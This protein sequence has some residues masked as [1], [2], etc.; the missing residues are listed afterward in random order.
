MSS[1]LDGAVDRVA[2]LA[3]VDREIVERELVDGLEQMA[4]EVA[5]SAI[6]AG[7]RAALEAVDTP[8][9]D[10]ATTALQPWLR[11]KLA[12]QQ[13][14]ATA[15]PLTEAARRLGVSDSAVRHVVGTHPGDGALLG[16]RDARKRWRIFTYQLPGA[17]GCGGEPG[18]A[19]GRRVQQALPPRMH[20][21]AVAAWWD[22]PHPGLLTGGRELTPR[23]WLARGYSPDRLVAAAGSEDVT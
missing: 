22:A 7:D 13:M 23:Q 18:S 15:V 10:T 3:Q 11:G 16:V 8:T 19:E 4:I 17:D 9:S 21:V 20:P 12:W 1:A 6:P 2:E 14:I 5:R